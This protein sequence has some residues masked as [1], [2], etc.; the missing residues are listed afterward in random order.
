MRKTGSEDAVEPRG[1]RSSRR[2]SR[3]Y[4]PATGLLTSDPERLK[5]RILATVTIDED[6]GCFIWEGAVANSGYPQLNCWVEKRHKRVT[7]TRLA[8]VLWKGPIAEG[9]VVGHSCHRP[10]CVRPEHLQ[11]MTQSQNRRMAVERG[12]VNAVLDR[13]RQVPSPKSLKSTT[14]EGDGSEQQVED[15]VCGQERANAS[16]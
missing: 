7:V 2:K 15:T 12:R 4:A 16:A 14:G 1:G 11:P 8:V 10:L 3:S 13:L 5:A 6:T 9:L